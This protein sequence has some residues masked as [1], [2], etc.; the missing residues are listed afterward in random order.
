MAKIDQLKALLNT[1]IDQ[2]V[3]FDGSLRGGYGGI[4]YE[5]RMQGAHRVMCRLAHGEPS[6]PTLDALHSCD[7]PICINP[8]HLRWGTESENMQDK[9]VR[10]RSKNQK[11]TPEQ[12]VEIYR[13]KGEPQVILMAEFN[14]SQAHVSMVQCGHLWSKVTGAKH[15]GLG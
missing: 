11:L 9:L 10:V 2:C 6:V 4:R 3:E 8:N 1:T 5:G 12:A 14:I 15:A 13:R 7:N